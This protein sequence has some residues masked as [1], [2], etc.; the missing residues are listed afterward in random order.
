[1]SIYFLTLSLL[2]WFQAFLIE[3]AGRKKLMGYGYLLMGVTMCGLTVTLSLKVQ[4]P[5]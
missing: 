1:M 4:K 3:R 5:Q 2:S